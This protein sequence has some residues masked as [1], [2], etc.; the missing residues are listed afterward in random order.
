MMPAS[1]WLGNHRSGCERERERELRGSEN[2]QEDATTVPQ[3]PDW[4]QSWGMHEVL[5]CVV[6]FALQI[7]GPPIDGKCSG[8]KLPPRCRWNDFSSWKVQTSNSWA[9][10]S[11]ALWISASPAL[12][13]SLLTEQLLVIATRNFNVFRLPTPEP[14]CN[15]WDELF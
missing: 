12:D 15:C 4:A 10:W 5:T 6:L 14:R 7:L 2:A 13:R 1:H 8:L 3:H 9:D 11:E